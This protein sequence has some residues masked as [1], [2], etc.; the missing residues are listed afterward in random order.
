MRFC[1]IITEDSSLLLQ[2]VQ[3]LAD[4]FYAKQ[5]GKASRHV[6]WGND[7]LSADFWQ[8][9]TIQNL[10][11]QADFFLIRNAE[12]LDT[13]TWKKLTEHIGTLRDD[14]FI[15]I[16]LENAWEKGKPKI[17]VLI[18]GQKCYC[19]AEK[20]SWLIKIAALTE[21]T[22]PAYV[23]KGM[24]ARGLNASS[25]LFEK[26]VNI[27]GLNAAGIDN[28]LDQ[29]AFACEDSEKKEIKEEYLEILS[30]A[31]AEVLLFDYLGYIENNN[32]IKLW[33]KLLLDAKAEDVLFGFIALMTREARQLWQLLSSDKVSIPPFF[34]AKKTAMAKKMGKMKILQIFL[35]CREAEWGLKSG[36]K[37]EMQAMEELLVGLSLL[38]R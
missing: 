37:N 12:K 9:L 38:Y 35:L 7:G 5:K 10:F 21:Q 28:S 33:E 16:A 6:Y 22:K 20:K 23:K 3:E 1:F 29:L 8:K 36:R 19:F 30:P 32:T 31:S 4:E 24:Q 34:V 2:R 15:L 18:S 26:L 13:E 25:A 14:A 17:P 11:P 27:L